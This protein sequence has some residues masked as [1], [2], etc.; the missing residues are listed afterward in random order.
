MITETILEM[1]KS[2]SIKHEVHSIDKTPVVQRSVID[3]TY[4]NNV[5]CKP[6]QQ[7]TDALSGAVAAVV[8]QRLERL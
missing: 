4:K 1:S 3:K 6:Q 7:G 8:V 5:N 2:L